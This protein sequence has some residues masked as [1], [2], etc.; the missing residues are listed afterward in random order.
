MKTIILTGQRLGL[1]QPPTRNWKIPVLIGLTLGLMLAGAVFIWHLPHTAKAGILPAG[2]LK[3]RVYQGSL[4]GYGQVSFNLNPE[5][6]YS[7]TLFCQASGQWWNLEKHLAHGKLLSATVTDQSQSLRGRLFFQ[8]FR[9]TN[10]FLQATWQAANHKTVQPVKFQCVA[11]LWQREHD[12][13]F[14]DEY[15]IS[16][17]E[18]RDFPVFPP[19]WHM[20]NIT[21]ALDQNWWESEQLALNPPVSLFRRGINGVKSWFA[22]KSCEPIDTERILQVMHVSDQLVSL[23]TDNFEDGMPASSELRLTWNFVNTNG[24]FRQFGLA[25]LFRKGTPWAERLSALCLQHLGPLPESGAIKILSVRQMNRFIVLPAGLL[26]QFDPSY[27]GVGSENIFQALIPW[28]QIL[29]LL[30]TNGP[31][32]FLVANDNRSVKPNPTRTLGTA[33]FTPPSPGKQ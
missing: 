13:E 14:Y 18:R 15:K 31:S 9:Q 2:L 33:G 16:V 12:C 25:E 28:P 27:F 19:G 29:D 6:E 17:T 24:G 32:R 3:E 7:Q 5:S 30:D 20:D 10:G 4:P 11:S 8:D 21:R 23:T 1:D 26:I 22:E